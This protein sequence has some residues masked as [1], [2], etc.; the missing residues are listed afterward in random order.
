MTIEDKLWAHGLGDE[1][2]E[3]LAAVLIENEDEIRQCS[4]DC[5]DCPPEI[6]ATC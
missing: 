3:V 6:M 2:A 4:G 5:W 1:D